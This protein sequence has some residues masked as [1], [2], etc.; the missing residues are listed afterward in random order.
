MEIFKLKVFNNY[1]KYVHYFLTK[2]FSNE[3]ENEIIEKINI[4]IRG[5]RQNIKHYCAQ[6][7]LVTKE[8]MN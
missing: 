5:E 4:Y 7:V 6:V 1:Y 2:F 3:L 8:G